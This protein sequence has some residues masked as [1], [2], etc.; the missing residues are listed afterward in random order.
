MVIVFKGKTKFNT[1]RAVTAFFIVSCG[2]KTSI[3]VSLDR[4]VIFQI[5]RQPEGRHAA[6]AISDEK[7]GCIIGKHDQWTGKGN[8]VD[9]F[10]PS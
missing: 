3:I 8:N 4:S 9:E 1:N 5:V 10:V 7:L 6:N 2:T